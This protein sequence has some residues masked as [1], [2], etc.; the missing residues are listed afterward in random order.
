MSLV[1]QRKRRQPSESIC[2]LA[3]IGGKKKMRI[4]Y[5]ADNEEPSCMKCD[6]ADVCKGKLACGPEC[7]WFGYTRTVDTTISLRPTVCNLC[8]GKVIYTSNS[9]VYGKEYGNGKCY[10]CTECG[11]YV[12]THKSKEATGILAN[13][14]MRKMKKK[15]LLLFN[16]QWS[17]RSSYKAS[18]KA[19]KKAYSELAEKLGISVEECNFGYFDLD[20][21]NKAY[22][23]LNSAE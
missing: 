3:D 1:N 4:V 12:S 6:F 23:I 14:Q 8:G 2:V 21:L 5:T 16:K 15:C 9:I 22:E 13:N 19:M 10:L 17:N 11:A 7:G 20:M 18:Q